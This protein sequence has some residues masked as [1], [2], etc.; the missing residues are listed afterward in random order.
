MSSASNNPWQALWTNWTQAAQG[1]TSGGTV[2]PGAG[3]KAALERM[4]EAYVAFGRSVLAMA[5]T[6][7]QGA[8]KPGTSSSNE[9]GSNTLGEQLAGAF[10]RWAAGDLSSDAYASMRDFFGAAP[11]GLAAALSTLTE[12]RVD[13]RLGNTLLAWTNEVLD[14]PAVGPMRDWQ[15]AAQTLARDGLEQQRAAAAVAKHYQQALRSAY[16]RFAAHLRDPQG[17]PIAS[18]A[19]FY[20]SWVDIAEAAYA[21]IVQTP[22][23]AADFATWINAGSRTRGRSNALRE[24]LS[25][26]LDLPQRA[27]INALLERQHEMHRELLRLQQALADARS[28]PLEPAAVTPARQETPLPAI[29]EQAA[30]PAPLP[31]PL[32]FNPVKAIRAAPAPRVR[33]APSVKARRT[34]TIVKPTTRGRGPAEFDIGDILSGG[35]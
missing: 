13:E 21:E 27:E 28:R 12:T 19:G 22:E 2:P 18:L 14:L 34:T 5:T 11:A 23:F 29:T 33:T 8:G 31:A 30:V 26:Q 4:S 16:A 9:Q 1:A 15:S 20:D 6:A 25:A 3:G 24:R 32:P 7:S 35:E 17:E 10:E